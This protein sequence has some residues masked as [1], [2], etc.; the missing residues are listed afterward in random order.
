MRLWL[1]FNLVM[2]IA[3]TV[4]LAAAA[5]FSRGIAE[6]TARAQVLH[7]ASLLMQQA[8]SVRGYTAAEIEPL[9]AEQSAQRFLPHTVPSWAAQQVVRTLQRNFPDYDYKEAALNPTNPADRATD[10]EADIISFFRRDTAARE[11]IGER[12]TPNG[13]VLTF[14]RPFRI[15][16]E[17]CLTCHST[18]AAAPVPMV[19]LYGPNNG[20]GWHMGEVIGAQIVSVPM[21]LP[22]GRA[23]QQLE[24][25]LISLGAVF[26]AMLVLMNVLL[27]VVV[28][29]PIRGMTASAE[30]IAAG[31]FSEPEFTAAG[32]DEIASLA[33]SFNLM[34]RSLANA[35]KLLD[36]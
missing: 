11:H 14:S 3:F 26:L 27:H 35:M 6:A 18:P 17:A 25:L 10:W 33:R 23:A 7:E 29:K 8:T 5:W 36:A 2:I 9:L 21:S 13:P 15:T 1:K 31:D 19:E 22:L 32:R 16:N 12:Q 34:R 30:K 24:A 4:G 28:I 20:F